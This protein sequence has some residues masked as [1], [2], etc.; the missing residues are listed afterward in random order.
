MFRGWTP[1]KGLASACVQSTRRAAAIRCSFLSRPLFPSFAFDVCQ[2]LKNCTLNRYFVSHSAL[3]PRLSLL[4][5]CWFRIPAFSSRRAEKFS[6]R[7]VRTRE[8]GYLVVKLTPLLPLTHL[9]R[10]AAGPVL[11]LRSSPTISS[12]F[13][14]RYLQSFHRQEHQRDP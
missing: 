12:E 1:Q 10:C 4:I 3:D 11:P 14:R 8:P 6:L 7:T 9:F 2:P 5:C 13:L